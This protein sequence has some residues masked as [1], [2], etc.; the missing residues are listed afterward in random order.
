[1]TWPAP[2]SPSCSRGDEGFGLTG[3]EAIAAGVPLI[4]GRNSGLYRLIDERLGGAG[5]GC[6]HAIDIR[7]SEANRGAEGGDA[8]QEADNFRPED[9][10]AVCRAVLDIA[11]DPDGARRDALSLRQLLEDKGCTWEQAAWG[12]AA[13]LGIELPGPDLRPTPLAETV[14]ATDA[15]QP[16]HR[17]RPDPAPTP[18]RHRPYSRSP[19]GTCAPGQPRRRALCCARTPSASLS[20]RCGSP[21]S[22]RSW[23]GSIHQN[24]GTG[25]AV[26]RGRR[27]QRQD[28]PHDRGLSAPRQTELGWCAGFLRSGTDFDIPMDSPGCCANTPRIRWSWTTPRPARPSWSPC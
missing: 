2:A 13:D 5:R 28:A 9:A 23:T 12:F 3:W 22:P 4:L 27:W 19:R 10:E 20:T 17:T 15:G 6:V 1:M 14:Q 8:D 21:C 11:A 18:T 24:P 25:H 16:L 26:A 7:G